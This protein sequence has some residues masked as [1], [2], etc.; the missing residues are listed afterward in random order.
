MRRLKLD[1]PTTT[2]L[3]GPEMMR[4][5]QE[6]ALLLGVSDKEALASAIGGGRQLAGYA[7]RGAKILVDRGCGDVVQL[8]IPVAGER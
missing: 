3:L 5:V 2:V 8:L 1:S 6:S 7:A 4:A